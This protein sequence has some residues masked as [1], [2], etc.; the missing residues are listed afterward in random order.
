MN[1]NLKMTFVV[2]IGITLLVSCSSGRNKKGPGTPVRVVDTNL[3]DESKLLDDQSKAEKLAL[4][5]EQLVTPVAFMYADSVFDQALS[6]DSENFRANF[7]KRF[8]APFMSLKGY[9]ARFK[10]LIVQKGEEAKKRYEERIKNMPNSGLKTFLLDGP[11]DI[12]NEKTA[13]IFLDGLVKA[14]SEFR[15]FLEKNKD[16]ELTLNINSVELMNKAMNKA[17][18]DC[19]VEQISEGVFEYSEECSMAEVLQ[20]KVE[21]ADFELLKHITAG[22]EIYATLLTAYDVTGVIKKDEIVGKD[23]TQEQVVEYF[24]SIEDFGKIRENHGL[25]NIQAMGSDAVVGLKWAYELR[26][27]LC[28][29]GR[30]DKLNRPGH[31]FKNGLCVPEYSKDGEPIEQVLAFFERVMNAETVEMVIPKNKSKTNDEVRTQVAYLSPLVNP[32]VDLKTIM[33][34][35]FNEC[36]NAMDVGEPTMGGY[37][38]LGDATHVLTATGSLNRSC[39]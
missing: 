6:I 12:T 34:I 16:R 33:P 38:P 29:K 18:E 26:Q 1:G 23:A 2:L 28:P 30:E 25:K 32:V 11:E 5:G 20:V 3:T 19:R 37:F 8:L 24:R 17:E 15:A 27:K 4:A 36:G 10:P 9:M 31:L 35:N 7:Y 22:H 39:R 21:R 14:K 13:Q